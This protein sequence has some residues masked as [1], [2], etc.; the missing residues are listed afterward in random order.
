MD[1]CAPDLPL[2]GRRGVR[3]VLLVCDLPHRSPLLALRRSVGD[4]PVARTFVG[5]LKS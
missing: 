2:A 1:G 3:V 5:V 4:A